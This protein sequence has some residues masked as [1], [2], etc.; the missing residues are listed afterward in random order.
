MIIIFFRTHK[1]L[2]LFQNEFRFFACIR[3]NTL[4]FM[5]SWK[6]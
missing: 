5:S 4:N 6:M 3:E 2:S 1:E